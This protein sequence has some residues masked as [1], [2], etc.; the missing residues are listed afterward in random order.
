MGSTHIAFCAVGTG[1]SS[2]TATDTRLDHEIY[3]KR[4]SVVEGSGQQVTF[5]TFFNQ[6]EANAHIREAALFGDN[7]VKDAGVMFSALALNRTKTAGQTLTLSW[8]LRLP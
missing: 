5:K 8:T 1:V 4:I 6:N 7:D 2:I 3:R